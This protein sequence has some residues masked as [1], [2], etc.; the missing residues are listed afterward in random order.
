MP[1]TSS[2]GRVIQKVKNDKDFMSHKKKG[3]GRPWFLPKTA[4]KKKEKVDPISKLLKS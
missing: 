3:R 2:R 1:I 4:S